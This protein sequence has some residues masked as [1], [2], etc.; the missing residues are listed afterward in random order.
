MN[1]LIVDDEEY[2]IRF[3]IT[4]LTKLGHESKC[5]HS[6]EEGLECVHTGKYDMLI[7]DMQLPGITGEEV[8]RRLE[9][10]GNRIPTVIMSS[11][12]APDEIARLALRDV[13]R[14]KSILKYSLPLC[15][16]E[17]I[18]SFITHV[19]GKRKDVISCPHFRLD[20]ARREITMNDGTVV[21]PQHEEFDILEM[22]VE[23]Q[24][25][26]LSLKEIFD[27]IYGSLS[28]DKFESELSN[29]S[30]RIN[31]MRTRIW[32]ENG[33]AVIRTINGKGYVIANVEE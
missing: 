8:I 14:Y 4:I 5:V 28:P 2:E 23:H 7:L 31:R 3:L 32:G 33:D 19:G 25:R 9:K 26:P 13:R 12:R 30:K 29:L 21:K 17:E 22:L 16:E 1:I 6:G 18:T 11:R 27:E 15:V 24:G 10:E 20:S